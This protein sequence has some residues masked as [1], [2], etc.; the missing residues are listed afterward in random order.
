MET[1]TDWPRE[2]T[3]S[4][5]RHLWWKLA[6]RDTFKV[7]AKMWSTNGTGIIKKNTYELKKCIF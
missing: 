7:T 5:F 3:N 2:Q 6:I 4:N 1:S